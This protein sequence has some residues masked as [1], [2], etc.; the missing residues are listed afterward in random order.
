MFT[1]D[2]MINSWHMWLWPNNNAEPFPVLLVKTTT[3]TPQ[4]R[5]HVK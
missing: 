5:C 3:Q 2:C 1:V 4:E